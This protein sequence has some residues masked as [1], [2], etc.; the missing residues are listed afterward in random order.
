MMVSIDMVSSYKEDEGLVFEEQGIDLYRQFNLIIGRTKGKQM[1]ACFGSGFD[2]ISM[3][4]VNVIMELKE[5]LVN[6]MDYI[7]FVYRKWHKLDG[8]PQIHPSW[9]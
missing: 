3:D 2:I 4:T 8:P 6:E 7:V 9:S 5:E 1:V